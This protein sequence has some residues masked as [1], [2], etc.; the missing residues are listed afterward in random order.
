MQ[1][2]DQYIY[3]FIHIFQTLDC[4]VLDEDKS[5]YIFGYMDIYP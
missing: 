2:F 4:V 5:L 3:C 1:V